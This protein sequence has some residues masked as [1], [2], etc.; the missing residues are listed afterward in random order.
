[1]K[2]STVLKVLLVIIVV[3]LVA[4]GV[5]YFINKDSKT[6]SD[7][8]SNEAKNNTS[9]ANKQ[10][11]IDNNIIEKGEM[12]TRG[13]FEKDGLTGSENNLLN[14]DMTMCKEATLY[15]RVISNIEDYKIYSE[16]IDI[17]EMTEEDFENKALLIVSNENVREPEE[18]DLEI[19]DVVVNNDVTTVIMKQKEN[20]DY[21]SKTNVFYAIVSNSLIK[22]DVTIV[23]E[24][25]N[26]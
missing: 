23:I 17:P 18:T 26:N 20:P 25:N 11:N 5:F 13:L 15:Y 6:N 1:M 19:S 3:A 21:E 16:R 12:H 10:E 8:N 2:K 14:N 22:D 9:V 4:F 24:K 7:S